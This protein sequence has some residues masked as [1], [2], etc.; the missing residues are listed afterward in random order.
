MTRN[1]T[2][3]SKNGFNRNIKA[4]NYIEYSQPEREPLIGRVIS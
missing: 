1:A 2:Q 4:N 3:M